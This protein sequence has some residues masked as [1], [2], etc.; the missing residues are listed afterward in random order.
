[1][2]HFLLGHMLNTTKQ[3]W[4]NYWTSAVGLS[5]PSVSAVRV[6]FFP[7]HIIRS[8]LSKGLAGDVWRSIGWRALKTEMHLCIISPRKLLGAQKIQYVRRETII[9]CWPS[10][11]FW[12]AT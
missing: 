12:F 9:F 7:W 2:V 11:S 10:K 6:H 3:L 8:L 5:T 1:M 4:Q